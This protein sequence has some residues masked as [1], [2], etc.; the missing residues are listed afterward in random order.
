ML[1]KRTVLG[2]LFGLIGLAAVIAANDDPAPEPT[3]KAAHA[4]QSVASIG[5]IHDE[6]GYSV[7]GTGFYTDENT[8]ITNCHVADVFKTG[9]DKG[10]PIVAK[11]MAG[12][13]M[14]VRSVYCDKPFDL[15]VLKTTWPNPSAN[16]L[17]WG[18]ETVGPGEDVWSAGYGQGKPLQYK[19]GVMGYPSY[20]GGTEWD[21]TT[22]LTIPII[23][24]DSGSP[25]FDQE[26]NVTCVINSGDMAFTFGGRIPLANR[27][28][29]INMDAK[30]SFYGHYYS[31]FPTYPVGVE[32][33][34]RDWKELHGYFRGIPGGIQDMEISRSNSDLVRVKGK[35]INLI[36][37]EKRQ[38]DEEFLNVHERE[39]AAQDSFDDPDHRQWRHEKAKSRR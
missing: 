22:Q 27:G 17:K 11:T 32:T 4:E 36:L 6:R 37:A 5:F 35:V 7:I 12:D 16:P 28:Y 2:T 18:A 21:M 30:R 24:G 26:G 14:E 8:L 23:G 3:P 31:A 9:Y 15:A 25:V 33:T 34:N 29:C 1:S 13:M 10:W 39:R 38:D 20:P 19:T